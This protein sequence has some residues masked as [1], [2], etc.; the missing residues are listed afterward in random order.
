[1]W[2][3]SVQVCCICVTCERSSLLHLCN[4]WAFKFVAFACHVSVQVCCICV[5]CERS[6]LLHLCDVW[7]FKF[8]ASVWRV[9]VQVYCICVTCERS[10]LLHLCD[11]WAF[12]FHGWLRPPLT[13]TR[14]RLTFPCSQPVHQRNDCH[15]LLSSSIY[16]ESTVAPNIRIWVPR[17]RGCANNLIGMSGLDPCSRISVYINAW[18]DRQTRRINYYA[19]LLQRWEDDAVPMRSFRWTAAIS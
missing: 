12:Y 7:G 16:T 6:S 9:S 1:M 8:V 3:G 14:P 15:L 13:L 17:G 10:S 19:L 18:N 4:V 2:P 5:T 11:V